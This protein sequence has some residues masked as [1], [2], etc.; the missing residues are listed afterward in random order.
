VR[1]LLQTIAGRI[2]DDVPLRL[3]LVLLLLRPP[4]H[5]G[6]RVVTWILAVVALVYVPLLRS[7]VVWLL[8]AV[9]VA[10]RVGLEWPLPDNHLYLLAYWC[11]AIGLALATADPAHTLR[12]TSRWL[13]GATFACA[14]AWKALFAPDFLDARFFRVT[15]LTDDRFTAL[16]RA[17][18][19][20]SAAQLDDD[21]QALSPLPAGTEVVDGPVLDEPGSLR[22]LAR[23]LTWSGIVLEALIALTFLASGTRWLPGVR[24]AVLI[25]FC[26]V[27]YAIAPVGGF[28][29]LLVTMALAHAAADEWQ[30][31]VAYLL[32]FFLVV[33]YAEGHVVRALLEWRLA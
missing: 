17:V 33:A 5:D 32:V 26:I 20:L 14:V 19:G 15:L 27:T 13:I 8:L 25:A 22:A 29:W 6:L 11:L 21:G 9:T 18:G 31:R 3:T 7:P 28:G 24:H 16:T 1:K 12:R 10:S 30:P 4:S 2:D 23:G